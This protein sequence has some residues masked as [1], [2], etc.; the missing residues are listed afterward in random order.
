MRSLQT[1][2]FIIWLSFTL[3][4]CGNK[5]LSETEFAIVGLSAVTASQAASAGLVLVGQSAEHR[6]TVGLTSAQASSYSMEL[7]N[8]QWT[9]MAIAW[10]EAEVMTGVTRC[11]FASNVDL[12]GGSSSVSLNLSAA[13][14]ANP[15]ISSADS[16]DGTLFK[17]LSINSCLNPVGKANNIECNGA[18]GLNS[19]PGD[20]Q[21]FRLRIP[22]GST[23]AGA[24]LSLTSECINYADPTVSMSSGLFSSGLRIPAGG[25]FPLPIDIIGYEEIGDCPINDGGIVYPVRGGM[26]TL[27]N[28][29]NGFGIGRDISYDAGSIMLTIADNYVGVM[30][31]PFLNAHI[32]N[33]ILL[34]F[35]HCGNNCFATNDNTPQSG[36]WAFSRDGSWNLFG[37]HHGKNSHDFDYILSNG[38]ASILGNEGSTITMQASVTENIVVSFNSFPGNTVNASCFVDNTLIPPTNSLIVNVGGLINQGSWDADANSP[39]LSGFGNPGDYYTVSFAGNFDL[40]GEPG[41]NVW[42]AGDLVVWNINLNRWEKNDTTTYPNAN[43]IGNAITTA[44]CSFLNP[45]SVTGTGSALE[46]FPPT[47]NIF[48]NSTLG[49]YNPK[50]RDR[51][52][53]QKISQFLIGPV[54]A[55]LFRYGVTSTAHLCSNSTSVTHTFSDGDNVRLNLLSPTAS[56]VIPDFPT[57]IIAGTFERKIEILFNGVLEEAYY[58]NCTNDRR[59]IGSFVSR[60]SEGDKTYHEQAFWDVSSDIGL[61]KHRWFEY[62]LASLDTGSGKTWREYYLAKSI[63]NGA[64]KDLYLWGMRGD[65]IAKAERFASTILNGASVVYAMDSSTNPTLSVNFNIAD[66]EAWGISSGVF[67]DPGDNIVEPGFTTPHLIPDYSLNTLFGLD[68]I[69]PVNIWPLTH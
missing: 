68:V 42:V 49:Q 64:S 47:T 14:C 2:F 15:A 4:S 55:L 17:T 38:T 25:S 45:V 33:E 41:T 60:Q 22:G 36:G 16:R 48:P 1:L 32:N 5:K 28:G 57:A 43:D 44:N 8:G 23:F 30:G 39:D 31:S 24:L 50:E 35:A 29:L 7:P 51:G 9:F 63:L 34:P 65:E 11:A 46:M 59:G 40:L 3:C 6:F 69:S 61:Q 26:H 21:S 62:Y 18:A 56:A 67:A 54:G 13:E 10:E 12:T 19:L 53:I 37:S 58:F 27:T 66:E 20:S 52:S